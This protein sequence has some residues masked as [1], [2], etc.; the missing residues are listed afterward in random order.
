M[1]ELVLSPGSHWCRVSAGDRVSP[2]KLCSP[3]C[4][5]CL[6][7]PLPCREGLHAELA[8]VPKASAVMCHE[9]PPPTQRVMAHQERALLVALLQSP[10]AQHM[11]VSSSICIMVIF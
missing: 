11:M 5:L 3:L 2:G 10:R 7:D 6:Q 4:G 8:Q 9:I 1:E